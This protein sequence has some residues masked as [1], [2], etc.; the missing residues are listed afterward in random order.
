MDF[1]VFRRE[2]WLSKHGKRRS[3]RKWENLNKGRFLEIPGSFFS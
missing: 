3:N 2:T 1:L